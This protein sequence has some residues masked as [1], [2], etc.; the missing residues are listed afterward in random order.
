[1]YT[2]GIQAKHKQKIIKVKTKS[3]TKQFELIHSDVCRPFS[4]PTSPGHRNYILLIDDNTPYTS[5][6]YLPD[7]MLKKWTSAYQSF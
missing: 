6:S 3:T 5:V 7:M 2:A 1:M 4:T